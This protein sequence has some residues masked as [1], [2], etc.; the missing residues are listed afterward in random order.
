MLTQKLSTFSFSLGEDKNGT[1]IVAE[2]SA[3]TWEIVI[4]RRTQQSES[5]IPACLQLW[6]VGLLVIKATG[7]LKREEVILCID[8]GGGGVVAFATVNL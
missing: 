8:I 3:G 7:A 1:V 2:T 5:L 4:V 6:G